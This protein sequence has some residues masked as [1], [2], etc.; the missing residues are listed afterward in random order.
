LTE[1]IMLKAPEAAGRV[2]S[3]LQELGVKVA[4]DDFGTGYSS[5]A[6]LMHFSVDKLKID[7]SFVTDLSADSPTCQIVEATIALA[8]GLG[9]TVVAEGID[10]KTQADI[11]RRLGCGAGQGFF[12]DQALPAEIFSD[13]WL[14]PSAQTEISLA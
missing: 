11:L 7:N 13:R 9:C 8:K 12:F 14:K 4:I 5:L 6:L 3:V 2:V 1:N 10:T